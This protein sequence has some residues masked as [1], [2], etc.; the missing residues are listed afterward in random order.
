MASVAINIPDTLVPRLRAAMRS[1]FPEHAALSDAAAFKAVTAEYWK[2]I[3]AD[4]EYGETQRIK[5]LE[6][7]AAVDAARATALTDGATIT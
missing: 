1:R 7:Q 3:L 6:Y 5:G 2:Q 4:Y